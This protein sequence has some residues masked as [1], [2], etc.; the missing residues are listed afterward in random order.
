M[1]QRVVGIGGS[2]GGSHG[3]LWG[4]RR[5]C[6]ALSGLALSWRNALPGERNSTREDAETGLRQ[7]ERSETC[8][9]LLLLDRGWCP[10]LSNGF[11]EKAEV[12]L[13]G[14]VVRDSPQH[15]PRSCPG[16]T[17]VLWEQE[18]VSY[19]TGQGSEPQ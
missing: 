7:Q 6:R 19:K 15:F 18:W 12:V 13:L 16:L 17:V 1:I 9:A 4:C 8:P 3:V 14:S 5:G 11:I 10:A 2:N